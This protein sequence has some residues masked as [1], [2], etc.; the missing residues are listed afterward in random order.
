VDQGSG[1]TNITTV[2]RVGLVVT[3]FAVA[4]LTFPATGLAAADA[5]FV[6]DGAGNDSNTCQ[7]PLTPCKTINGAVTKA[8]G[9]MDSQA[10]TINVAA[11]TY[12]EQINLDNAGDD[13]LTIDGVNSLFFPDTHINMTAGNA[14]A[15][16]LERPNLTLKD[17][18][19]Q[20]NN[21]TG[22][23]NAI[24][25]GDADALLDNV[26]ID[27]AS[28]ANGGQ[29]VITLSGGDD[30]TLDGVTIGGDWGGTG[31]GSGGSGLTVR[32]SQVQAG[33]GDNR[34]AL[35]TKGEL[36]LQRSRIIVPSDATNSEGVLVS[37]ST[38]GTFPLT[39][40]SSTIQGG[41]QALSAI[42]SL[43]TINGVVR[44]TTLDSGALGV[45]DASTTGI[46]VNT[47]G[48]G[49]ADVTIANSISLEQHNT[50]AGNFPPTLSCAFSDVVSQ[51]NCDSSAGNPAGNSSSTPSALF[52]DAATGDYRLKPTSPAVDTGSTT[53][54]A[55]GESAT[56]RAGQPRIVD[57]NFD[58]IARRDKGAFELQGQSSPC[59]GVPASDAAAASGAGA[60]GAGAT[61]VV[62]PGDGRAPSMSLTVNPSSFAPANAGGSLARR[63]RK[64][65]SVVTYRLDEASTVTFTV[66]KAARGRRVGR[67]CR[68][69][70]RRNRKRRR[71]TRLVRVRGSFTHQGAAGQNRFRF[72]GRLA[73]KALRP[74]RYRLVGSPVD[75]A[76]NRG[77]RVARAFRIIR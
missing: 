19:M 54:L 67:A 23:S 7:A 6:D 26:A 48:N 73:R 12:I 31:V 59:P 62:A 64:T 56:D 66:E 20:V 18:R 4:L 75:A 68:R 77:K 41:N 25:I 15:V 16:Q 27:M 37:Q 69:P 46:D 63:K 35:L 45:K 13:G 5:F 55:A 71:C 43:G 42:A 74:G 57:G 11:G 14:V 72:T 60:S 51:P 28:P 22:S 65:G 30:L 38:A 61:G 53:S 2:H 21:A 1:S 40:D 10:N 76:G 47:Q 29:A 32:D 17:L 58:C 24:A 52:V 36:L 34:S 3:A 44:H 8:R 49:H 39:V 33:H 9:D 70:T 50:V